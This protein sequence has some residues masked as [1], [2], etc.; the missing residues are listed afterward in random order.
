MR[1]PSI[2]IDFHYL[3]RY[4]YKWCA[5]KKDTVN[6]YCITI[7]HKNLI[8]KYYACIYTYLLHSFAIVN[9][10]RRVHCKYVINFYGAYKYKQSIFAYTVI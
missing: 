1:S 5:S 8:K 10:S 7:Q 2:L 4:K 6:D 9:W 3:F